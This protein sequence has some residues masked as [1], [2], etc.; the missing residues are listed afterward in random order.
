MRRGNFNP[1]K[2]NVTLLQKQKQTLERR[3]PTSELLWTRD[4]ITSVGNVL[5][6]L[7]QGYIRLLFQ[8]Q[9]PPLSLFQKKLPL[10]AYFIKKTSFEP[11]F[12]IK[13]SLFE[14]DFKSILGL[15]Y[16]S[17]YLTQTLYGHLGLPGP[18]MASVG[19][20]K[21]YLRLFIKKKQ[22]G[23]RYLKKNLVFFFIKC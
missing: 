19:P 11:F 18:F 3:T 22:V 9:I 14:A 12:I 20:F 13:N 10:P 5:A 2:R 6:A 4:C 16:A 8:G 7:R 1:G 15:F 21:A 23:S 17:V